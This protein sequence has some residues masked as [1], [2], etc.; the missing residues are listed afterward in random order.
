VARRFSFVLVLLSGGGCE[1]GSDEPCPNYACVNEAHLDGSVTIASDVTDVEVQLC[2]DGRCNTQSF[3][4][5]S[6]GS[7][8][9]CQRWDDWSKVCMA[10]PAAP[11][12]FTLTASIIIDYGNGPHDVSIATLITDQVSGNVLFDETRI[13]KARVTREDNCHTCWT[14]E[15]TL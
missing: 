14:A 12:T 1:S 8:G 4:L 2:V 15:A 7:D 13:A 6:L 3:D 11:E 5:K 10:G 9:Q